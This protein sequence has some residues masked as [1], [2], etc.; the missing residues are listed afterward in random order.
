MQCEGMYGLQGLPRLRSGALEGRQQSQGGEMW[1]KETESSFPCCAFRM[2]RA[3]GSDV[4]LV[5]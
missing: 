5:P 2:G 4:G 1:V 3:L